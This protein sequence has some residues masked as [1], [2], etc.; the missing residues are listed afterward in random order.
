VVGNAGWK[1]FEFVFGE[2]PAAKRRE[3]SGQRLPF[4]VSGLAIHKPPPLAP[5]ELGH[6]LELGLAGPPDPPWT[7][8]V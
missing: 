5:L 2:R 1:K 6:E 3:A 8:P 4:S 7:R